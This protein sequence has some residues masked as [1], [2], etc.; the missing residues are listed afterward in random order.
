[1]QFF[2]NDHYHT[3]TFIFKCDHLCHLTIYYI[4][5]VNTLLIISNTFGWAN[6]SMTGSNLASAGYLIERWAN[7]STAGAD[8]SVKAQRHEA[9]RSS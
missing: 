2:C 3:Y 4:M 9:T 1:M 6:V 7:E 8:A 5:S